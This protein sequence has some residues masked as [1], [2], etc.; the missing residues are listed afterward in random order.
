MALFKDML[1]ADESLFK[2]SVALDYDYM[3]KLIK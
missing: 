3:P 1:K 2:N